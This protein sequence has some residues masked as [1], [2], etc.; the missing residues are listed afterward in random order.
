MADIK[1]VGKLAGAP[2]HAAHIYRVKTP[3]VSEKAIRSLAN[4]LGMRANAKTGTLTSDEEKL[5]YFEG[6]LRLTI[7]RASGGIRLIDRARWQVDDGIS[8]LN[9]ENTV[10]TRL[11]QN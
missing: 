3:I 6:T 11:A 2:R 10:A 8:D 1:V 5:I 7:Y 9:I 4:R